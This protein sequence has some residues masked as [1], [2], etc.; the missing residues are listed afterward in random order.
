M[1]TKASQKRIK[2]IGVII[3]VLAL[4]FTLLSFVGF[5]MI[6]T[7]EIETLY[8]DLTKVLLVLDLILILIYN[9]LLK[10]EKN[11]FKYSN[12]YT[13]MVSRK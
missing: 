2:R 13:F 4:L 11:N 6:S 10:Q 1:K 7:V 9:E 3:T 5:Y 12:E 8:V